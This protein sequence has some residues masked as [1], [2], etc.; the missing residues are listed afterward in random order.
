MLETFKVGSS[1]MIDSSSLTELIKSNANAQNRDGKN[2][3]RFYLES[4]RKYIQFISN[5]SLPLWSKN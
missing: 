3:Y 5:L 2:T 4:V 1:R